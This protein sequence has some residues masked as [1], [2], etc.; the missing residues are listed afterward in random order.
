MESYIYKQI[1]APNS[2]RLK[3][4]ANNIK[5]LIVTNTTDTEIV[6]SIYLSKTYEKYH[7]SKALHIIG[8]ESLDVF[9]NGYSFD[10]T[11]TLNITLESGAADVLL[12][13]DQ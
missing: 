8:N 3:G 13:L 6:I 2:V 7:I 4:T 9:H 11:Y 5:S 1:S 12:I 10:P